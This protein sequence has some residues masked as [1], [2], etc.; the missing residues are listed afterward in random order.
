MF[1]ALGRTTIV[2]LVR[3]AL[4]IVSVL[5]P[6]TVPE[7]AVMVTG[8]PTATLVAAPLLPEALLTVAIAV[9]EDDHVT[10]AVRSALLPS[11]YAPVAVNCWVSPRGTVGFEVESGVTVIDSRVAAVTV[12]E[13]LALVIPPKAAAMLAPPIETPL[14]N[15]DEL[16]D[17]EL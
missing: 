3:V 6:L 7:V 1:A 8:P 14:D 11:E 10:W 4:D 16:M 17:A 2:P 5:V 15:P 9:F 13:A 12:S